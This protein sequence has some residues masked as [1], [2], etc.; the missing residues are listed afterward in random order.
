MNRQA[1]ENAPKTRYERVELIGYIWKP[2]P[3]SRR[4][5][6]R[7]SLD[8]RTYGASAVFVPVYASEPMDWWE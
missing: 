7:R 6:Y 3:A 8:G 2:Y 4:W 1:A 5:Q